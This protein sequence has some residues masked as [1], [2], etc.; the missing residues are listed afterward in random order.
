MST[1]NIEALS[2]IWR[3][4]FFEEHVPIFVIICGHSLGM[5]SD[6]DQLYHLSF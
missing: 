3:S 5:Q 6:I 2:G 1:T 4:T